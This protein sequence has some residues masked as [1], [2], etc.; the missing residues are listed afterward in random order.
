MNR[1]RSAWP[2]IFTLWMM[3]VTIAHGQNVIKNEVEP[4]EVPEPSWTETSGLNSF[5]DDVIQGPS[6]AA[7]AGMT[8]YFG[9]CETTR[10]RK[11]DAGGWLEQGFSWNSDSPRDRNNGPVLFN[12]RSNEYQFNQLYFYAGRPAK[13]D[14][15]DFDFGF[16]A[17]FNYG[18]DSR[19]VSSQGLELHENRSRRWSS[20]RFYGWAMPQLYAE[21]AFPVARGLTLKIGHFYADFGYER[22]QAPENFFYSHSYAMNFSEPYTFTGLLSTLK[23]PHNIF[24]AQDR[25]TIRAGLTQGW[26][27]WSRDG[28]DWG[29]FFSTKLEV[30]E[31]QSAFTFSFHVG[32]EQTP[33][34]YGP[35]PNSEERI[36]YSLV[37]SKRFGKKLTWIVQQNAGVQLDGVLVVDQNN[38]TTSFDYAKWYGLNNSLLYQINKQWAAGIRLEWFADR[39]GLLISRFPIRFQP[40]G[41][42]FLNNNYFNLTMGL[43]WKPR[44]FMV[45]RPELRIDWSDLRGNPIVGNPALRTYDD[46]SDGN[47]VLFNTDIII[48]Y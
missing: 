18:T 34:F 9:E 11:W 30:P 29:F 37:Y 13:A 17:D 23:M 46:A 2:C 4:V 43:N 35:I 1:F 10:E 8:E 5:Y 20:Y 14:G 31:R 3:G 36:A 42:L 7:W 25:M 12:D 26:D 48:R 33:F 19:F 47:Q 32:E 27:T 45:I 24:F 38:L 21:F 6:E 28:G 16:R 39:D 15:C 40:S 22:F 44:P 41:D